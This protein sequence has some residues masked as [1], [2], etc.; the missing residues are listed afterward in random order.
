MSASTLPYQLRPNKAVDRELFLSLLSRISGTLQIEDYKY[1]GLGGPFLEDFR[2]IHARL[3]ITDMVSVEIEPS[4]HKRQE[5]NKPIPSIKCLPGTLEDYLDSTSLNQPSIIWLDYTSAKDLPLQIDRFVSTLSQ[6]PL[7]SII[8][9][10][11]NAHPDALGQPK[12]GELIHKRNEGKDGGGTSLECWRLDML[13]Q[14]LGNLFV[15]TTEATGMNKETYGETLLS[16]L[17][18]AVEDG[19]KLI[20]DRS[21]I[22]ALATHY[23]D[24]QPMITATVVVADPKLESAILDCLKG[25]SYRSGPD[26]P[27]KL[28]MP[29]LS[30]LER[31]TMESNPDARSLISYDLQDTALGGDPFESFRRFYRVFPHFARVDL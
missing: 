1:I 4:V 13:K 26:S 7:N 31:L 29:S 3:G 28:N 12:K 19:K 21:I 8:R 17:Y 11:L 2:L 27:H 23:A 24:G 16:T 9:I 30:T 18:N 5:F 6:V 15:A 10:T 25:W 14:R 22:W 20:F